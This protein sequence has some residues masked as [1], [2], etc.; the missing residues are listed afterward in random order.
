MGSKI[1]DIVANLENISK[2]LS[3]IEGYDSCV[4]ELNRIIFYIA[5][6]NHS[7][8]VISELESKI[9]NLNRKASSGRK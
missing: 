2:E 4:R 7:K 5:S 9:K 6:I 3:D 8:I 1:S